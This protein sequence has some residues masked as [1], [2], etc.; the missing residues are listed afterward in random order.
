MGLLHS[1][2]GIIVIFWLG[3]PGGRSLFFCCPRGLL[4]FF[5]SFL[6][7]WSVSGF[8]SFFRAL[9]PRATFGEECHSNI[10]DLL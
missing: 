2:H 6:S 1:D 10:A 8:S 4:Q 7:S 5:G 9:H 3:C